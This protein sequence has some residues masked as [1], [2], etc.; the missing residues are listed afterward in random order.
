MGKPRVMVVSAESV[1]RP[2]ITLLGI[3]RDLVD[4]SV[5]I[6][7]SILRNPVQISRGIP[8]YTSL[9]VCSIRAVENLQR[10]CGPA[11]GAGREFEHA[12]FI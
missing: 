11:P 3:G 2:A 9:R 5:L 6:L 4:D 7:T 1:G 10:C 8:E 12:A